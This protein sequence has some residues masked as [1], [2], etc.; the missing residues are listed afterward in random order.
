MVMV[1]IVIAVATMAPCP[2]VFQVPTLALRLSAVFS[3]FAFRILQFALG[4][5]NLLLALP[6]IIAIKRPRGN[7]SAQER[8][9]NKR[10]NECFDFLEHASSP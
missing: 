3:V 4:I 2:C 8:Q 5:A 1:M 10:R 6:V 7:H 9:N